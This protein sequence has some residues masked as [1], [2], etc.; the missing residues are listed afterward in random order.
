VSGVGVGVG[1][2]R[3]RVLID[4]HVSIQGTPEKI[5]RGENRVQQ[6]L[7]TAEPLVKFTASKRDEFEAN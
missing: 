1:G 3:L 6:S 4:V 5:E 7:E 2:G